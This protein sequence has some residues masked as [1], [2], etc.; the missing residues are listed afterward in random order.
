MFQRITDV[1][2]TNSC[3]ITYMCI[4][5]YTNESERTPNVE[6]E[7]NKFGTCKNNELII[8]SVYIKYQWNSGTH[9]FEQSVND[10][11]IIKCRRDEDPLPLYS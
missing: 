5:I 4:C 9:L 10:F 3:L 8:L 11:V 7:M 2:Y 6:N 1:Y